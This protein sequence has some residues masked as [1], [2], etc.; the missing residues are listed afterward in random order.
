[1]VDILRVQLWRAIYILSEYCSFI[2]AQCV[3][4]FSTSGENA[5]VDTVKSPASI[6]IS[7]ASPCES[8]L[9]NIAKLSPHRTI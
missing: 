4:R 7:V 8:L 3:K 9:T 2:V 1:M 6:L 5:G